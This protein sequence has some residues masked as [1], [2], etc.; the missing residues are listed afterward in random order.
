MILAEPRVSGALFGAVAAGQVRRADDGRDYL[1]RR[2]DKPIDVTDYMAAV[3]EAGYAV[4]GASGV[5]TLT[6]EGQARA[7]EYAVTALHTPDYLHLRR[8]W[9]AMSGALI[10]LGNGEEPTADQLADIP[11][12]HRVYL[13]GH[14]VRGRH[15]AELYQKHNRAKELLEEWLRAYGPEGPFTAETWA[16]YRVL[17]FMRGE[18]LADLDA[19]PPVQLRRELAD[20]TA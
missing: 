9:A 20:A 6:H 4:L 12:A 18:N 5:W 19:N 3:A 10:R 7:A 17:A 14:A 2:D 15:L 1:P 16:A 8:S 11:D 13:V